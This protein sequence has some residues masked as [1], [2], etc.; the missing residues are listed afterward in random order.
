MTYLTNDSI[1]VRTAEQLTCA[2][3]EAAS[4]VESLEMKQEK[5]E[6]ALQKFSKN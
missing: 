3:S 2:T 4:E 1:V 5:G 6:K